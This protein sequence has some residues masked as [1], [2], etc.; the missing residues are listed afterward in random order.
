MTKHSRKIEITRI[1]NLPTN[2]IRLI[3]EG[4][5]K[6]YHTAVV[7]V[8]ADENPGLIK[9]ATFQA[10]TLPHCTILACVPCYHIHVPC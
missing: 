4:L 2:V 9:L 6:G 7:C 3:T 8:E 1:M 10:F 5:H